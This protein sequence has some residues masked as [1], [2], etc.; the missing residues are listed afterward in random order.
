MMVYL[1]KWLKGRLEGAEPKPS[2]LVQRTLSSWIVGH[3]H[4]TGLTAGFRAVSPAVPHA[5][6]CLHALLLYSPSYFF[7][8]PFQ[9]LCFLQLPAWVMLSFY[10]LLWLLWP[11]RPWTSHGTCSVCQAHS[12][13]PCLSFLLHGSHSWPAGE[14]C[15]QWTL[16]RG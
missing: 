14:P 5:H 16:T 13:Q 8:S 12:A 4:C 3:G 7:W 15:L 2:S 11:H 1:G 9:I 10:G 6:G